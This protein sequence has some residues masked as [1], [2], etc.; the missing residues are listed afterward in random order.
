MS[1][2]WSLLSLGDAA[3]YNAKLQQ[4]QRHFQQALALG[5]EQGDLFA[6]AWARANLGRVAHALGDNKEAQT[7]YTASL[8][9][10]RQLG[11]RH[12][13]AM[14]YLDLGRLARTQG[15]VAQAHR[16]YAESLIVFGAVMDKRGIPECLEGI[17]G[18]AGAI[19]QHPEDT[20]RA[21]RLFGAA[22]AWRAEARLPLP[23]V[24]RAAYKRDLAAAR[25]QLDEVTWATTWAEGRALLPKQVS[26]E[27]ELALVATEGD[28]G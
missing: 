27:A 4:A 5:V 7:Y 2:I 13:I 9:S 17:A 21:A 24:H 8:A 6:S 12:D 25:A 20:Q 28:R 23:P 26:A 15:H 1:L 16:Y 11:N 14:V 3:F 19:G 22:Q 10:F 18:L